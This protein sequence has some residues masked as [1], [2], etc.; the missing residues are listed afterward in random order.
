MFVKRMDTGLGVSYTGNTTPGRQPS[1][2]KHAAQMSGNTH[3]IESWEVNFTKQR[4][5]TGRGRIGM[6]LGR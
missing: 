5:G 6:E 2:R 3:C 4:E 1:K